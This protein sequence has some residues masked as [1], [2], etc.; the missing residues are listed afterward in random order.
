MSD[1]NPPLSQIESA[2]KD[3]L[4]LTP[5]QLTLE[6]MRGM[7][8]KLQTPKERGEIEK[9]IRKAEFPVLLLGDNDQP[10]KPSKFLEDL[11]A[12]ICLEHGFRC[13]LGSHIYFVQQDKFEAEIE[14]EMF[15]D[16]KYPRLIILVSG[17]G[18]GT[19]GESKLIRLRSD[20]NER[21]I[22]FFDHERN[23][24]QLMEWA[25]KKQFPIEYKYPIPY[26]G[27]EELHAKIIF[28]LLH[29][30]YGYWLHKR[31]KEFESENNK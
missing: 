7:D 15:A 24:K 25:I 30:F 19:I 13:A 18:F 1:Q 28:G 27:K 23:Y 5:E 6:Y 14:K 3:K 12:E 31:P 10:G 17:K 26:T 21:T 9:N 8:T 20:L 11:Q 29:W 22:F 16:P 2:L 4:K